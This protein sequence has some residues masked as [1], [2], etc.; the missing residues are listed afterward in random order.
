MIRNKIR[1][2][3]ACTLLPAALLAQNINN[4]VVE[5]ALPASGKQEIALSSADLK[6]A[7]S[8]EI[9]VKNK[10]TDRKVERLP[11][12]LSAVYSGLA[13]GS[14]KPATTPEK[15]VS[16]E[17]PIASRFEFEFSGD[18]AQ[19]W[20]TMR[21]N[22]IPYLHANAFGGADANSNAT[23]KARVVIP[24]G[25]Q[26]LYVKLAIPNVNLEGAAEQDAPARWQA[27]FLAELSVNGYP[28]WNSEAIRTSLLKANPSV[29]IP[30]KGTWMS[31]YG[32]SLTVNGDSTAFKEVTLLLGSFTAGQTVDLQ[33]TSRVDAKVLGACE[34]KMANGKYRY[35]CTR[36]TAT[37]NWN[38]NAGPMRIYVAQ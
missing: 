29:D 31:N 32:G 14:Y 15:A 1:V 6:T 16:A 24:A 36:A 23:W 9:T 22:G 26:K 37:V 2:F 13:Q 10:G 3:A 7:T 38:D 4:P 34:Y 5:T 28:V 20:A 21:G 33:F 18:A 12:Q 8:T 30:E 27:K 19:A 11:N 35:F 25:Y 17:P